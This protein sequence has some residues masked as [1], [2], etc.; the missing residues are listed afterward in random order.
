MSDPS[1]NVTGKTDWTDYT[2][3]WRE[4][5]AE[6]LMYRTVLRY[7][8]ENARSIDLTGTA[9]AGIVTYVSA[10]GRIEFRHGAKWI[11]CLAAENLLVSPVIGA[12]INDPVTIYQRGANGLGLILNKTFISATLPFILGAAATVEDLTVKTGT[13]VAV[14]IT[15]DANGLVL[16][17]SLTVTPAKGGITS[18]TLT[19]TGPATIANLTAPAV[20][21]PTTLTCN[22]ML[23]TSTTAT[24]AANAAARK[25]Y[26]DTA[27]APLLSAATAATTYV[28]V[29]G[30]NTMTNFLAID[31]N[32]G[33]T[34]LCLRMIAPTDNPHFD[35]ESEAGTRLAFVQA[36]PGILSIVSDHGDVTLN[37][38]GGQVRCSDGV[39]TAGASRFYAAGQQVQCIGADPFVGFF[40]GSSV[41]NEGTRLGFVG[42]VNNALHFF[43]QRAT[44]TTYYS[45]EYAHIFRT[46][47]DSAEFLRI[48]AGAMLVGKAAP[49][50]DAAGLEI[51]KDGQM[52]ISRAN[53]GQAILFINRFGSPAA[54]RRWAEFARN[55]TTLGYI[56]Q[57]STTGVR[58]HTLSD[59]RSK[60]IVGKIT[61]AVERVKALK[62]WRV[63]WNGDPERGE[64]D[65]LIAHELAEVVPDA[66][67]GT[68][69]GPEMQG[70]DYKMAVPLL[71]AGLQEVISR[72]EHLE[73]KAA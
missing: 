47:D 58:Y 1:S 38:G 62:P 63:T 42:F 68:K 24:S 52:N 6:W 49:N 2:H 48:L 45:A 26:V 41:D 21:F 69:D 40:N 51:F 27:V 20:T 12:N 22:T 55:S 61:D 39:Y 11:P 37:S 33:T 7:D 60:T 14:K 34:G 57:V 44:G 5:D 71:A 25:D 8:T 54:G 23:I 50:W 29:D 3:Y 9:P 30:G 32:T 35:F 15:T 59:Y 65:S 64:T 28:Q 16:N 4:K 70:A 73:S 31:R 72:L 46:T 19:V 67:A 56:D 53:D 18:D 13:N 10:T 66:V 36:T 43:N 17:D